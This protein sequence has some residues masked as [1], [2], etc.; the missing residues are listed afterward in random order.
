MRYSVSAGDSI[1]RHR[2]MESG[3]L[4]SALAMSEEDGLGA[5]QSRTP[6]S[7]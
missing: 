1:V 2:C 7:L 6:E 4:H 3:G 5:A